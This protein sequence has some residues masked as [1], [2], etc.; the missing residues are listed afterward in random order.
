M[1]DYVFKKLFGTEENKTILLGFLNAF[2]ENESGKIK[3][4]KHLDIKRYDYGP[5]DRDLIISLLC[6]NEKDEQFFVSLNRQTISDLFGLEIKRIRNL[7]TGEEIK[8]D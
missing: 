1:S 2:L 8:F 5:D 4:V 3:D 7:T 6:T